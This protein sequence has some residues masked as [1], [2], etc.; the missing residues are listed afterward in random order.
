MCAKD[1]CTLEESQAAFVRGLNQNYGLV[2]ALPTGIESFW[3]PDKGASFTP[4]GG[5]GDGGGEGGVAS[6]Q[7]KYLLAQ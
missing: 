1:K 5:A 6:A 3:L 4:K 7:G 2:S